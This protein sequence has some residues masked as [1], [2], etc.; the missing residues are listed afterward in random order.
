[1]NKPTLAFNKIQGLIW[2]KTQLNPT[3]MIKSKSPSI[4]SLI[5]L[6]M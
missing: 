6:K 2:H 4:F 1:M 5:S 3:K